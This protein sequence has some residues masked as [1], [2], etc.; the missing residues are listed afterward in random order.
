MA[1]KISLNSILDVIRESWG[2]DKRNGMP[3]SGKAVREAIQGK[4]AELDI[5]GGYLYMPNEKSDDGYYSLWVFQSKEKFDEWTE[6]P[7]RY[8]A[9]VLQKLTI[10]I[11]TDKGTT[12][13]ARLFVSRPTGQ[14]IVAVEKDF[15][16]GVRYCGC[17]DDDGIADNVGVQ[18]RL[19][20]QRST[21]N[22]NTWSEVGYQMLASRDLN[23]TGFVDE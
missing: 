14:R 17:G 20:I 1:K 9:N 8:V 6:D 19:S 5:R 7:E 16:V 10:P 2:L 13:S 22:G 12:Y 23:A 21:D 11:S 18:G 15:R 3:Y 4:L